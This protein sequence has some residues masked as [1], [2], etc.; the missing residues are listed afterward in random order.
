MQP[1]SE[2]KLCSVVSVPLGVI[3]K[4]VPTPLAPPSSVVPYRF[5]SVA[6]TSPAWGEAPSVIVEAVK[7]GQRATWG[8]FEDRTIA[9][10]PALLRC[11]VEVPIG[12][13]DQRRPR[14]GAVR[15]VKAVQRR[16]RLRR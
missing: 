7:R 16:Q 15:A 8:D 11:P 1:L 14:V 3:L 6:W 12:G 13:L 5:P 4:T 2:Q 10:G 9:I